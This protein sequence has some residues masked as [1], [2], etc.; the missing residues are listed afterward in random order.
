LTIA[1]KNQLIFLF[2]R[3][4]ETVNKNRGEIAKTKSRKTEEQNRNR[5]VEK[6]TSN[7][8]S[9]PNSRLFGLDQIDNGNSDDG[10]E[11]KALTCF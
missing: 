9:D 1:L 7:S 3:W 2:F 10:N 8:A 4:K 11:V 6:K 5:N